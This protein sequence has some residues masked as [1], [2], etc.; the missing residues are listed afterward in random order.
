MPRSESDIARYQPLKD[1]LDKTENNLKNMPPDIW[2]R[3]TVRQIFDLKKDSE[4][5]PIEMADF[6]DRHGNKLLEILRDEKQHKNEEH[7]F[8]SENDFVSLRAMEVMHSISDQLE[9]GLAAEENKDKDIVNIM[10][11][12]AVLKSSDRFNLKDEKTFQI[13]SKK[14]KVWIDFPLPQNPNILHKGGFPRVVLKIIAGSSDKIIESELPPNDIDVIASGD[15]D[16]IVQEASQM[17]VDSQG[18]ELVKDI[19][20]HALLLGSRDINLNC[21]FIGKDYLVYAQD[22]L[23]AAQTEKIR[24]KGKKRGIYGTD[25]FE[26]DKV[27]LIKNRGMMRMVKA[28]IEDKASSFDF[29]PLNQQQEFGI[30]W[31]V[32]SRKSCQ[33]ENFPELMEKL[34]YVNKQIGQVKEGEKDIFDV[35]DRIHLDYP[36]FDFEAP[37][38]DIQ[39][40]ARWLSKKLLKQ[41]DKV[42]RDA[43][44]IGSELDLVRSEGDNIPYTVSTEGFKY[45]GI[46]K[47]DFMKKWDKFLK[48]CRRRIQV[49]T[50][51]QIE[52]ENEV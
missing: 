3:Q 47:E 12:E 34:Y 1:L 52:A 35:L 44:Q 36:F 2:W 30:Y 16:L 50:E 32:L 23:K 19:N 51:E 39:G 46:S 29:L 43:Y 40:S 33:K 48:R 21:C 42:Y 15:A 45:S 9:D 25:L 7:H 27:T 13:Y 10:P 5:Y 8:S 4:Q 6:I 20:E 11:M 18:I 14:Q 41:I 22:A 31:L 24:V 49:N 17:G 37:Q 28:L 38:L 26:Y